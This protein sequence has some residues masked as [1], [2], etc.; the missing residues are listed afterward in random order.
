MSGMAPKNYGIL[1]MP[2][3]V[4]NLRPNNPVEILYLSMGDMSR[5]SQSFIVECWMDEQKI[6]LQAVT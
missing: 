6:A 1:S 5:T 3:T 2:T 4:K